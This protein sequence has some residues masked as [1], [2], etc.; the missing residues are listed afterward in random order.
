VPGFSQKKIELVQLRLTHV[1]GYR[2]SGASVLGS[3]EEPPVSVLL[4]IDFLYRK[5][6]QAD[7]LPKIA[8]KRFN[9][10]GEAWLPIL[11]VSRK[12][13][14]FTALY[15]NKARAHKLD[16]VKDWVLIFFY[17]KQHHEG[18]HTVVTETKGPLLD[19]RVVRGREE[20]CRSHY[21]GE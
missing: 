21:S 2:R 5:K 1:L 3:I 10:T 13:W 11:H 16:K 14:H 12:G 9:P 15:S 6:A 19:K 8:P 4:Q 7:E 17:D 18:Q 20:E